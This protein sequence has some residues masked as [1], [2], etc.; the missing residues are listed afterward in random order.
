MCCSP[1][2]PK[3][4]DTTERLNGTELRWGQAHKPCGG[5][6]DAA[7]SSRLSEMPCCPNPTGGKVTFRQSTAHLIFTL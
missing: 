6:E 3:E 7:A 5:G 4:L 2:G 1:W